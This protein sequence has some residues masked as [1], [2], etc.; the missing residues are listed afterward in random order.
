[1]IDP[2]EPLCRALIAELTTP[3]DPRVT[4]FVEGMVGAHRPLGVL[5]YGSGLREF[6]PSGILDFYIVLE[7]LSDWPASPLERM[8][9]RFLPPN[10]RYVEQ[11]IDGVTLRAKVA[12]IGIAQF[13]ALTSPRALD[14]TIWARF[15]QPVRLAW[16]RDSAAADRLLGAVRQS[17]LTA[18]GWAAF[19]GTGSATPIAWWRALFSATYAA[20]LRVEKPGR[21]KALMAGQ[22]ER[23]AALLPL[24]WEAAGLKFTREGEALRPLLTSCQSARARKRWEKI[25]R[26]GRWL[27]VARLLKGA[28]TFEGGASYLAWKIERHNGLKLNLSPFEAKH[29]LLCLPWLLW[30][31]RSVLRPPAV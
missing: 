13:E 30:R 17:V 15:C 9:N 11:A 18:A 19:L 23:F 3:T 2:Q 24:A 26:R 29:P 5:F 12:F 7:T 14:T 1:M 6:D 27:N 28:F 10:V 31:A 21:G 20:E 16:V 22:E 25:A 8:A 4:R